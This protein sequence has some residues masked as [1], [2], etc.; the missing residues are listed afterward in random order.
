MSARL[1][2]HS[3]ASTCTCPSP[4]TR[5]HVGTSSR[6]QPSKQGP[7][8]P[9]L[10]LAQASLPPQS[11]PMHPLSQRHQLRS[12]G[13]YRQAPSRLFQLSRP[14]GLLLP[15]RRQHPRSCCRSAAPPCPPV[16]SSLRR[17]APLQAW[18]KLQLHRPLAC[19]REVALLHRQALQGRH[20]GPQADLLQSCQPMRGRATLGQLCWMRQCGGWSQTCWLQAPLPQLWLMRC[21]RGTRWVCTIV[22]NTM[23]ACKHVDATAPG[24]AACLDCGYC[25]A[26]EN[27]VGVPH[28]EVCCL[29]LLASGLVGST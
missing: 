21:S 17:A 1:W 10:H 23:P 2:P 7:P 28:I 16:S 24:V 8:A 6:Q 19:R 3:W 29:L 4:I 5:L 22:L 26:R 11:A 14:Q 20:F 25:A 15:L 9:L 27:W 12:R 13:A 18:G